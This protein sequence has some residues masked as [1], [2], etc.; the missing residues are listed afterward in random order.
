MT[1]KGNIVEF[2]EADT[3]KEEAALWVMRLDSGALAAEERA[4]LKAWLKRSA[5][6]QEAMNEAA[7]VWGGADMLEQYNLIDPLQDEAPGV[8]RLPRRFAIAGA[9][10]ASF[11]AAFAVITL[12]G[13]FWGGDVQTETFRTAI[14]EQR[15]IA[16]IDGSTIAL[17]T[18]TEAAVEIT[19]RKRTI[20]LLRG[21][22]HFE[23]AAEPGR[24][25]RVYANQGL[26]EAVGTAFSVRLRETDVEVIVVEGV[27]E[28][29]SQ[30]ERIETDSAP[31]SSDPAFAYRSLAALTVN[32]SAV[33][34]ERIERREKLD[35][36]VL[37]RKLMW[38]DGFLAFSGETL[39]EVVGEMSRYTDIEIE[40]ADPALGATPIAG[41]FEAGNIQG[42]FDSLEKV[43]GIK[44]E[45]EAPTRVRLVRES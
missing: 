31:P 13:G 30:G 45:I 20:R 11:V 41:S 39:A 3:I 2:P 15:T 42:M 1:G 37:E 9:M 23:V 17:N 4:E 21:E 16:L 7:A 29:F 24:P 26:V 44:A 40:I 19:R 12:Q 32:E 34:D 35:N 27:V 5:R 14:G 25:F 18:Y 28:L 10:A 6:H 33:F 8:W 36:A 22:A 43:F 38:R